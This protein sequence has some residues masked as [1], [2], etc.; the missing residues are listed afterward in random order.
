MKNII[1]GLIALLRGKLTKVIIGCLLIILGILFFFTSPIAH[2]NESYI[3]VNPETGE[4]TGPP[5]LLVMQDGFFKYQVFI[6]MSMIIIGTLLIFLRKTFLESI[7][8]KKGLI[9]NTIRTHLFYNFILKRLINANFKD[10]KTIK[11]IYNAECNLRGF[12]TSNYNGPQVLEKLQHL[13]H[14]LV[15]IP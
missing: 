13:V 10:K 6:S 1:E 2:L 7:K 4:W 3:G 15:R 8:K 11:N 9:S 5:E 14:R 12:Y